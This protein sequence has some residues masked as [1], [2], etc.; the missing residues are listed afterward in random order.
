[1]QSNLPT[2]DLL[3]KTHTFPCPYLF[4]IIGNAN[5]NFVANVIAVVCEELR[6]DAEPPYRTRESV[7]GRHISLTLEPSVQ[8][9]HQVLAIYR[10]LAVID[11]LVMMF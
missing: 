2:I 11:G 9:P 10:R 8:S 1:M 5:P 6:Y 4:K 3:E 7:G